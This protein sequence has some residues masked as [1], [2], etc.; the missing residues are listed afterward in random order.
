MNNYFRRITAKER[1]EQADRHLAFF[2]TFVAGAANAGGFMAV[3]QY[4]SHMSGVVSAMAD[5][6]VL[7]DIDLVIGGAGAFVAFVSGA[8]CSA[9]LVNWGRSLKLHSEYA[10]PLILE[11]FLLMIFGFFGPFLQK[12]VWIFIP[13]TV[14]LLCFIMGLQNAIITKL[15]QSRIR[16]THV[17]GITTDIGIELGKLLYWNRSNRDNEIS[18]V[19]ADRKKLWLLSNLCTLF[20]FGGIIGAYCFKQIGFKFSL[21]LS[22][23]VFIIAIIPVLDD[24]KSLLAKR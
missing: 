3:Q 12:S 17:T 9:I 23:V 21:F 19:R 4:T 18:P 24:F 15:S 8:A 13:S 20:F 10:F 11:A 5:N 6:L 16:T 7:G 1:S 22:F 14:A 2:L